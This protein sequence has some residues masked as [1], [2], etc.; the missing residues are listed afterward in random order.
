MKI[1]AGIARW[2]HLQLNTELCLSTFSYFDSTGRESR[3]HRDA[4]FPGYCVSRTHIPRDACVPAHISL[5]HLCLRV[6]VIYVSPGILFPRLC[7]EVAIAIAELALEL[8]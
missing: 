3:C 1:S 2:Y 7:C 6:I 5:T 8:A 4:C